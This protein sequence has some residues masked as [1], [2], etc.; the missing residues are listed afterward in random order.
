M[1]QHSVSHLT[2]KPASK[3]A[4]KGADKGENKEGIEVTK[5]EDFSEWYQQ[6]V[7]KGELI[8]YYDISGCYILRPNAYFI[9]DSIRAWF[10][11]RIRELGV[12]NAY[13]PLFVSNRALTAEADHIEG[14]APEV[15]WVT[16]AGKSDLP[17]PIAVRPTSETIMY[18][19]YSK[20]IRSHRSAAHGRPPT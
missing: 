1:K 8:E 3:P 5:S 4:A 16:K 19:A 12:Q 9:W 7:V 10:D 20:W 11:D 2:A 15:A 18:P 17:E 6:L 13:F 14:F